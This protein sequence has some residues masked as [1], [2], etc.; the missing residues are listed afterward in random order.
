VQDVT[1]A[2]ADEADLTVEQKLLADAERLAASIQVRQDVWREDSSRQPCHDGYEMFED[3][4]TNGSRAV[5][6]SGHIVSHG[7]AM[8]VFSV[9]GCNKGCMSPALCPGYAGSSR[10]QPAAAERGL[11]QA[12]AGTAGHRSWLT[13]S[14]V[15]RGV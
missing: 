6:R 7:T 8:Q 14:G 10:G 9:S 2:G 5:A 1:A 13:A 11:E 12:E 15:G 4:V 3:V